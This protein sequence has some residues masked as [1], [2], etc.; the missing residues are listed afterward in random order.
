M[1]VSPRLLLPKGIKVI[2]FQSPG[3][4]LLKC[5]R[6]IFN[7][8][9]S[10]KTCGQKTN[11]PWGR[12]CYDFLLGQKTSEILG[13][14]PKIDPCQQ[15]SEHFHPGTNGPADQ[16]AGASWVTTEKLVS[17]QWE[18]RKVLIKWAECIHSGSPLPAVWALSVHCLHTPQAH[19]GPLVTAQ[20]Q[21]RSWRCEP[22]DQRCRST[23]HHAQ[24]GPT[25]DSDLALNVS[26]SELEKPGSGPKPQISRPFFSI[27]YIPSGH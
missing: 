11:P 2:D 12:T 23:P 25:T 17:E 21:V 5:L 7:L 15:D 27:D 20:G 26:T 24:G 16:D 14:K 8:Y 13:W 18:T 19:T 3:S 1:K 22:R 6:S 10:Q 4:S 9:H